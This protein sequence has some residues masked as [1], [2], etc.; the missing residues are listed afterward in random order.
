MAFWKKSEDPWDVDLDKRRPTVREESAENNPD[1]VCP[2]DAPQAG[3]EGS[4]AEE[5]REAPAAPMRCPWCGREMELGYLYSKECIL[6][7]D[8]EPGAILGALSAGKELYVSD[9]GVTTEY[10]SCWYC[11]TCGRL[12][13]QMT[14]QGRPSSEECRDEFR[15]YAEQ[16][17]GRK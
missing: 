10:K 5:N 4:Q 3:A 15:R 13:I 12:V 16:A 11:S 7:V 14:G 2:A 9:E 6:W 1:A 17:K 8:Q